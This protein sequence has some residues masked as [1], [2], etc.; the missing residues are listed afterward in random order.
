[1]RHQIRLYGVTNILKPLTPHFF[2]LK[3]ITVEELGQF[4]AFSAM[5][6]PGILV[7]WAICAT[8]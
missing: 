6:P 7:S 5:R 1:M 3:K 4:S 8:T 2:F